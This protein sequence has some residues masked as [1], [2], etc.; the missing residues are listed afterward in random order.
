MYGCDRYVWFKVKKTLYFFHGS[1]NPSC[2]MV[3]VPFFPFHPKKI[4]L[5]SIELIH[6]FAI[7]GIIP[8]MQKKKKKKK[9]LFIYLFV[10]NLGRPF[11]AQHCSP[12]VPRWP[13][14]LEHARPASLSPRPAWGGIPKEKTK[15]KITKTATISKSAARKQ[16]QFRR[17]TRTKKNKP[18]P[19]M[20]PPTPWL[21]DRNASPHNLRV[22]NKTHKKKGQ[23]YQ[24][25]RQRRERLRKGKKIGPQDPIT[26]LK[27][28]KTSTQRQDPYQRKSKIPWYPQD[29]SPPQ[30]YSPQ[31]AD[32]R[33]PREQ[34]Y[35]NTLHTQPY[36]TM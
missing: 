5:K 11:N 7:V 36:K 8:I 33:T 16:V 3:Q 25:P 1:T 29:L 6:I 27:G 19:P 34:A 4:T 24:S 26:P 23:T 22:F 15:Q 20:P 21:K 14:S 2:G 32:P 10:L 9:H 12:M 18:S 28:R 17:I 31:D 13:C 35:I 30:P